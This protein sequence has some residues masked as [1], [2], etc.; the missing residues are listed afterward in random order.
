MTKTRPKRNSN[1][2]ISLLEIMVVLAIMALVVGLA[3]PR[4]IDSF[5]RGK[6]RAAE[7]QLNGIKAALQFYY[8]DVGR[9]PSEAEGLRALL[10]EPSGASGWRGPYLDKKADIQDPWGRDVLYRIPGK[11]GAFDLYSYGRD[12]HP[13][14]TREDRD[15]NL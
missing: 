12:G 14:G 6:S 11:E 8:I 1:A 10:Q 9:Y 7:I 4:V 15:I 5:G 2:G 3:A 13:G